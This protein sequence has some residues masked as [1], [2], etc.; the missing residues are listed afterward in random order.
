VSFQHN[1]KKEYNIADNS[2]SRSHE[3]SF[4]VSFL[5]IGNL[6]FRMAHNFIFAPIAPRNRVY[7]SM[8]AMAVSMVVLGIF[9]FMLNWNGT[10]A[11]IYVAYLLGGVGIG[12]FESNLLSAV[13]PLGHETKVCASVAIPFRPRPSCRF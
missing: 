13:T 2:S 12:S 5:Y 7:V 10:M 3:F 4:A 8:G 1:L 11:W 9:V 6:I